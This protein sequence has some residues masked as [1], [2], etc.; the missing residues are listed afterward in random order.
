M[1]EFA[2]LTRCDDGKNT[3]VEAIYDNQKTVYEA[4]RKFSLA[5]ATQ[6]ACL[7]NST[8][9]VVRA[10]SVFF[11]V[12]TVCVEWVMRERPED[13]VIPMGKF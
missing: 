6:T 11:I 8:M 13:I 3:F 7:F 5:T 2:Q 12:R 1:F 4:R 9:R 10:P